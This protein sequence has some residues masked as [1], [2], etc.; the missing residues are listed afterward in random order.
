MPAAKRRGS[1]VSPFRRLLASGSAWEQ[2]KNFPEDLFAG[3]GLWKRLVR[4]DLVAV[5]AVI[6]VLAD[7]TGRCQV[8]HDAVGASLSDVQAGRHIMQSHLRVVRENSSTR[9]WLLAKLPATHVKNTTT[10]SGKKL[11]KLCCWFQDSRII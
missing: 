3:N 6:L 4:H 5:A 8:V 7:V 2:G 11:Q 9:P 10:I 1:A